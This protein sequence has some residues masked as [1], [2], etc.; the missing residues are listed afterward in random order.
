MSERKLYGLILAGGVGTRL[1]P[2][3][4]SYL[5][6][7][8]LDLTGQ[9][10]MI[11]QTVDRIREVL[12]P[13]RLWI[14]TNAEYVDLVREQL[15]GVPPDHVVGEPSPRGTAPAIGL[16]AQYIARL[17]PDGIMFALH[18]DH[19]IEDEAGFREAMLTAATVAE[20]GWL[21][22]LGV[23]P[24][25]P[26]TGYGYVELGEA[27][28]HTDGQK[29][30]R[31]LCFR[32]KPALE[33]AEEYVSAGRF[34]WN[35]GIFCWRVDVIQD[36]FQRLIPD[37]QAVLERIGESVGTAEAESTL[38][39]EWSKLEGEIT[40][41]RGIMERAEKVATVPMDVGWNDVGAWDSLAL[42]MA[43][44]VDGNSVTGTGDSIILDSRNVY[45][46]SNEKFVAVIGV[47][48]LI[49][50]ETEDALLVL[51]QERAQ[52]VK[53]IVNLLRSTGRHELL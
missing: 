17:A 12:P 27:L 20:N 9:R 14:M 25:R 37:T 35:S 41:D 23:K 4:R 39:E 40:I 43:R 19:F 42:L 13:E 52:D 48:N 34:L 45:V 38:E 7:Q 28:D 29:A 44:D 15:P 5:P 6:K 24:T 53:E 2:R 22:N 32:E 31:V 36:E 3:S 51:T 18:A 8:M 49:V 46:H 33:V 47:D 21:V 30:Y 50:V 16:G 10:T 11:Q 26:E 1:W